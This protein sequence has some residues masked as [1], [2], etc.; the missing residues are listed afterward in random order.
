MTTTMPTL[1]PSFSLFDRLVAAARDILSS[2]S[3]FGHNDF[4]VDAS[5]EL[6]PVQ[7]TITHQPNK[8]ESDDV[9]VQRLKRDKQ[10]QAGDRVQVVYNN[11]KIQ[12]I[13]ITRNPPEAQAGV[14]TSV[15][16]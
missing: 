15:G 8:H 7:T 13:K 16:E 11:R 1:S 6:V 5:G 12:I 3:G 4:E 10:W 9:F 14:V 2:T